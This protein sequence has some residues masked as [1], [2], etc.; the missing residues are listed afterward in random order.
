MIGQTKGAAMKQNM[1][2]AL[3]TVKKHAATGAA[4]LGALGLPTLRTRR[5]NTAYQ[6]RPPTRGRT[7]GTRTGRHTLTPP[8]AAE[9]LTRGTHRPVAF[10]TTVAPGGRRHR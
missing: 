1:G 2:K 9:L 7:H 3:G 8:P 10:G 4:I 6:E 5:D